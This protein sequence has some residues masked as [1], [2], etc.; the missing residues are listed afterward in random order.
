MR[1][2]H[3]RVRLLELVHIKIDHRLK[4]VKGG[5]LT[6]QSREVRGCLCAL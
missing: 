3:K 1:Q 6:E 2:V 5:Q 4:K